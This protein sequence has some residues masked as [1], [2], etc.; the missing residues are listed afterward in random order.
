[1]VDVS[2]TILL[3]H[4]HR[5]FIGG[6]WI[7]PASDQ[8]FEVIDASTEQPVLT[9]AR[10]G[11]VDVERAVTAARAAFDDGEWPRL[12]PA[13]RA[14]YLLAIA[15]AIRRRADDF[16]RA[17]SL[18]SGVLYRISS[19]RIGD[20]MAGLFETYA[21]LAETFVFE[22]PRRGSGGQQATLVREAVGVV[23]AI[24]PWNSPG[25]LMTYK[26]APAL[27]SGCTVVLKTPPEAPISGYI[28]AEICEE[29]GLPA[30]V[31]NVVA[32]RRDGSQALVADPRVDKVTFTGSTEVGRD[33]AATLGQRIG[34]YTLELGG[35][36]PAVILDDGDIAT[37][38]KVVA[39]GCGMLTGQVCHSLTRIV[40]PRHRHDE[41]VDALA[42]ELTSMRIGDA[43]DPASQIGPLA[44][45]RQREAVERY[46]AIGIS[47]G[48]TLV[49]GGGRPSSLAH[50][51]YVEP[52][53]FAN[54]DNQST[55]G[56]EEIFGPVLSVI[57]ANDE[58]EAIRIANET[59]FGLNAS[60]FTNDQERFRRFASR[61]RS[62]TVSQNASRT[63]VGIAFGGYKQS[64]IGRE[65][66]VEGLMPFLETKVVVED[67]PFE[68]T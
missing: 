15:S 63:D 14:R 28:F 21:G 26:C 68:M 60:I 29:V 51:F 56:Q 7:E 4:P 65:G 31:V 66:G 1:M 45:A 20:I 67:R 6:Q 53:L 10:A 42:G 38:A 13:E 34:R 35:K 48:A 50:G 30:G 36:S 46:I 11:I 3:A 58:N 25:P 57:P 19:A 24:V 64:G 43:F 47:E 54:V 39:S 44:S 22:E 17:W 2:R 8:I 41:M 5:L 55:I 18:E 9:V 52:T 37:A 33:I 40:V 59:I 61:I 32:A 49:S 12:A 16:A 23:A 62:G 27:L